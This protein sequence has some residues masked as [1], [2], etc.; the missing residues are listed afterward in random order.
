VGQSG[1]VVA[2]V[3]HDHDVRITWPPLP[4]VDQALDDLTQLGG[5]DCGRVVG[6]TEPD[7]VQQAD[8]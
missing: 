8:P 3:H 6:R 5:G 2:G 4:R 7:R 1:G